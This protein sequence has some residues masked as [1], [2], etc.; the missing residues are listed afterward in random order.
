MPIVVNKEEKI[1]QL[2][3]QAYTELIHKGVDNFSL[4]QFVLSIDISK[5]QFYHYFSTK[6]ELIFEAMSQ[7]SF[8]IIEMADMYIDQ[9]ESLQDKLTILFSI[10]ISDDEESEN[11]RKLMLDMFHIYMHS[12]D[13][14]IK[15]YN[16]EFYEWTDQK[17]KE[18]FDARAKKENVDIQTPILV[19]SISATA[20]GMYLRSLMVESYDL[21]NELTQYLIEIE[22]LI[23][24]I[25]V[26]PARIKY[27]L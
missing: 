8:E 26:I 9:A 17:L 19:K 16:R 5:G 10:Y 4:N 11:F 7:K 1:K 25:N 23:I 2:C 18:I 22:K 21:K 14:R 13:L 3:E 27:F 20:D 24:K 15:Q 12:N 6:E